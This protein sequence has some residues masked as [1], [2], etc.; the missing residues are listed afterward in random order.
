MLNDGSDL[1]FSDGEIEVTHNAMDD[2][3]GFGTNSIFNMELPP[4][5]EQ[6]EDSNNCGF[7]SPSSLRG[8][9]AGSY[10]YNEGQLDNPGDDKCEGHLALIPSTFP[11]TLQYLQLPK[12]RNQ[13][14]SWTTGLSPQYGIVNTPVFA[15]LASLDQVRMFD[16]EATTKTASI[17]HRKRRPVNEH[18]APVY[19]SDYHDLLDGLK[20]TT[21]YDHQIHEPTPL[22]QTRQLSVSPAMRVLASLLDLVNTSILKQS[23]LN[24]KE[25]DRRPTGGQHNQ[26]SILMA[27]N[28]VPSFVDTHTTDHRTW[29]SVPIVPGDGVEVLILPN[30]FSFVF[31]RT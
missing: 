20:S 19:P 21:S 28:V 22:L 15:A 4:H 9:N 17:Q 2:L 18:I 29:R 30:K 27:S 1:E 23:G 10:G 6:C 8:W 12:T 25:T 13:P 11:S 26:W 3:F 5:N 31:F 7:M 24:C 16:E 14:Q